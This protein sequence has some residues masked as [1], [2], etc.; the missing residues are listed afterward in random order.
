MNIIWMLLIK[1]E[2]KVNDDFSLDK[3]E[4]QYF[5]ICK[6]YDADRCRYGNNCHY[7]VQYKDVICVRD[8]LKGLTESF[9]EK[10]NLVFQVELILEEEGDD[11]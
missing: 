1:M 8:I 10:S 6:F 3:L 7:E 4:C 2:T 5:D 9:V 11:K